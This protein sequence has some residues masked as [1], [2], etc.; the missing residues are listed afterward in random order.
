MRRGGADLH[1]VLFPEGE[2]IGV[3][4][5]RDVLVDERVEGRPRGPRP[6]RPSISR[7]GHPYPGSARDGRVRLGVRREISHLP[8]NGEIKRLTKNVGTF[9]FNLFR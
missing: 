3:P 1:G 6:D 9:L 4:E 7:I 8:T 5:H 2:L